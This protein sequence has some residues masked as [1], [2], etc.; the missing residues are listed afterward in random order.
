LKEPVTEPEGGERGDAGG[1]EMGEE[2]VFRQNGV[3]EKRRGGDFQAADSGELHWF[4]TEFKI[5]FLHLR[6]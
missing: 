6:V 2:E 5:D 3:S 1:R 4:A